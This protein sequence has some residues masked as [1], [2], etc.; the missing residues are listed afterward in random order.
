MDYGFKTVFP[1][2]HKIGPQ[3]KFCNRYPSC[4]KVWA[5]GKQVV[6]FIGYDAGEDYRSD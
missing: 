3:D 5:A 6:K 4:Y 2:K 1:L